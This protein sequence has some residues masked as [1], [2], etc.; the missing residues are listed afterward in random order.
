MTRQW[1]T[2]AVNGNQLRGRRL[3][4]QPTRPLCTHPLFG[5]DR[6]DFSF[7]KQRETDAAKEDKAAVRSVLFCNGVDESHIDLDKRALGQ[8]TGRV[9]DELVW[10]VPNVFA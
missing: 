6:I 9:A 2:R 7:S 4:L 10:L 5:R 3:I 8:P 1:S